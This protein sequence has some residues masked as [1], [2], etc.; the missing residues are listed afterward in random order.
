M[1]V[2]NTRISITLSKERYEIPSHNLFKPNQMILVKD[3][4]EKTVK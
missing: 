2:G 1:M 3:I 4:Y